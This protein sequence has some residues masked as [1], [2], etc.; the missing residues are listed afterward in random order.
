MDL[1]RVW[2]RRYCPSCGGVARRIGGPV[3]PTGAVLAVSSELAGWGGL[4]IGA[5][6]ASALGTATGVT[7]GIGVGGALYAAWF[8]AI[9]RFERK[10]VVCECMDCKRQLPLGE[11]SRSSNASRRPS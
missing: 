4:L 11:F 5:L 7:V 9:V 3:N 10:N 8:A 1:M 6:V 2:P